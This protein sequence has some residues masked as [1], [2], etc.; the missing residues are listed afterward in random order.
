MGV[1]DDSVGMYSNSIEGNVSTELG[2]RYYELSNHLGNVLTVIS[3]VKIPF[4][5]NGTTLD[6]YRVKIVNVSD[7]SP[8]GVQ[9]D[10]RTI[11]SED[12]R[13][14]FNGMEKDDEVKGVKGSS[15][16]FGARMYDPRVGRWLSTDPLEKKYP[17]ASSFKFAGNSPILFLDPNGEDIVVGIKY[18][19]QFKKQLVKAF[20]RK[21]LND[22]SYSESGELQFSGT[23]DSYSSEEKD[24]LKPLIDLMDKD[25]VANIVYEKQFEELVKT[26]EGKIVTNTDQT[27]GEGTLYRTDGDVDVYIDPSESA[28]IQ[29][30]EMKM[31]Y[32]TKDGR[33]TDN[34]ADPEILKDESGI[35]IEAGEQSVMKQQKISVYRRTFHGL[36]HALGKENKRMAIDVENA[37]GAVEKKV[38]FDESGKDLDIKKNRNGKDKIKS[39]SSKSRAH[40]DEHQ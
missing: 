3:D 9:L 2:H 37:A 35:P 25:Y 27:G 15:Y 23:P 30:R 33:L 38:K 5:S 40:D 24:L 26:S 14:G 20:G 31:H 32:F 6:G 1:Y 22:F 21:A 13:Y 10:G 36:G 34:R 18:Q 16:D 7:Y 11:T 19:K 28:G 29:T 17:F 39:K 8:F 4:S 12:Y